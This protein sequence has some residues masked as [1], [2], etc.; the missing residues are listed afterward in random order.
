MSRS[1]LEIKMLIDKRLKTLLFVASSS[2]IMI[3]SIAIYMSLG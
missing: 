2:I 3:A 1:K